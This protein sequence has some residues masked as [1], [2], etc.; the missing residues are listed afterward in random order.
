MEFFEFGDPLGSEQVRASRK[1][2]AKLDKGRPEDFKDA[3]YTSGSF[4]VRELIG[5]LPTHEL[6]GELGSVFK[7]HL[8][9]DVS[10]P[11]EAE[12]ADDFLQSSQVGNCG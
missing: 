8:L 1:N 5:I 10:E 3:A 12:N 6:A 7:A 9:E 2:L 4:E 11:G